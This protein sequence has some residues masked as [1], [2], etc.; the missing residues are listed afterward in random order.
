AEIGE[1][2]A[3]VP[4]NH[5]YGETQRAA[6]AAGTTSPDA[7][8]VDAVDGGRR[9]ARL[10]WTESLRFTCIEAVE[11]TCLERETASGVRKN[12]PD[13]SRAGS[14]NACFVVTMDK[15]ADDHVA[16]RRHGDAT[17]TLISSHSMVSRVRR[18]AVITDFRRGLC[19]M[20]THVLRSSGRSECEQRVES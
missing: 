9:D 16:R 19:A 4:L 11:F 7:R 8:I 5:C 13:V 14:V 1:A 6:G 3:V 20:V 18:H 15:Q 17:L 10:L 2:N 12:H